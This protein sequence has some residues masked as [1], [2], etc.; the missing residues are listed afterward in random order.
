MQ[1]RERLHR[2][3]SRIG[4]LGLALLLPAAVAQAVP[5]DTGTSQ[6]RADTWL[7]KP[8]LDATLVG[9]SVVDEIRAFP[10][11]G[12]RAANKEEAQAEKMLGVQGIDRMFQTNRSFGD[13]VLYFDQ[14][15]KLPGYQVMARV[16]TP[17]ATAWTVR[18]PDGGVA[19]AV[20]RNTSPTTLEIVEARAPAATLPR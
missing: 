4:L 7:I 5:L 18:R 3:W 20:V 17:S 14:Q 10:E 1:A 13:T 12:G 16:D 8:P 2:Q 19:N 11:M 6:K 15:F 9:T